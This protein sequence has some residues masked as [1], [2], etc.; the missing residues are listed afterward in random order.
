LNGDKNYKDIHLTVDTKDDLSFINKMIKFDNNIF[1][2]NIDEIV[3]I[4]N[5][6]NLSI[7]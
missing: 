5:K 2:K 1:E 4:Y 7:N 6:V 3:D